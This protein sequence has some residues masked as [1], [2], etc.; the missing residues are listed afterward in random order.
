MFD[1]IAFDAD[2]TLWHNETLYSKTQD[3]FKQLLSN[4]QSAEWIEQALYERE[5][6]NLQYFG[7]GIKGFAL[8]M[9]ETAIELTQGRISGAEIQEII[10]FARDML[11]A[12]V[13]LLEHA[14]EVIARLSQTY[15]L[16]IITKGDLFDQETKI[17]RSGL[18]DYFTH[19]EIVSDKTRDTYE[20]LVARYD[21]DLGRFL[22]VGNSLR[23]DILPIVAIGGQAV[24]IPFHITWAHETVTN[25]DEEQLG[26]FELEHIGLL[27]A[28]VDRLSN[29]GDATG[30]SQQ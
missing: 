29:R 9:I 4:Y 14:E 23:S 22:M 10:N 11:K 3:K 2:D 30:S 12:P 13:Q 19:F 24:Y 5:M 16:M 21:I 17:S 26:Y 20:A 27:P 7:Y 18:A 8:S 15:D 6:R 28:L 25:Q 1:L